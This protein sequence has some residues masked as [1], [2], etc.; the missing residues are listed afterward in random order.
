MPFW[1]RNFLRLIKP[2]TALSSLFFFAVWGTDSNC[3]KPKEIELH[4]T[5]K[6]AICKA[7]DVA[8]LKKVAQKYN[9]ATINDLVLGMT[10]VGLKKYM[11][12]RNDKSDTM[13]MIMPFSTRQ[14]PK[15]AQDLKLVNDFTGLNF[16][17]DLREDCL[18]ATKLVQK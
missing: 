17:I 8:L 18:E 4:G 1:F 9:K 6:N 15:R 3:I 10:S 14:I 11:L 2:I 5:K 16:T 12:K 13:N 7:F